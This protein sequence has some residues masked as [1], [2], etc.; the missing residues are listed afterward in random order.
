M[1]L[2]RAAPSVELIDE[3]T[4]EQIAAFYAA[5]RENG[6]AF[7]LDAVGAESEEECGRRSAADAIRCSTSWKPRRRRRI[8][9]WVFAPNPGARLRLPL[10]PELRALLEDA[11]VPKRVHDWKLALHVLSGLGVDA[12]RARSTTRCCSPMR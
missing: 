6:F 2:R 8:P 4:D 9:A 11:K 12:A 5:A 7:A 10:T 1:R 3:P